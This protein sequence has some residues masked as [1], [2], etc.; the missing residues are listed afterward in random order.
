MLNKKAP[1][2]LYSLS[3]K[4]FSIL[5]FSSATEAAAAKNQQSPSSP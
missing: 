4:I 3:A 2:G 5:P 1:F